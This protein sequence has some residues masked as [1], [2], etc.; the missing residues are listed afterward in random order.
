MNI[1]TKRVLPIL[2]FALLVG[3]GIFLT[4]PDALRG[5]A[6]GGC[7]VDDLTDNEVARNEARYLPMQ[8]MVVLGVGLEL[9]DEFS[10]TADA[11]LSDVDVSATECFSAE[12]T[13]QDAT[14]GSATVVFDFAGCSDRT[15]TITVH[16]EGTPPV[17]GEPPPPPP[18]SGMFA[19]GPVDLTFA[20]Y[21]AHGVML[22]GTLNVDSENGSGQIDSN[23]Q[24]DFLDYS[25]TLDADGPWTM[26][27]PETIQLDL[28]GTYASVTGLDW[29]VAIGG[30]RLSNECLGAL[31]GEMTGTHTNEIG[32]VVAVAH[33]DGTCDGCAASSVNDVEQSRI[34]FPESMIP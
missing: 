3:V 11:V 5:E 1:G 14:T 34:C 2:G 9:A 27:D 16:K 13:E 28:E 24:T 12:V 6:G 19:S 33:F 8:I 4:R 15:G 17:E 20:Q 7:A 30:L 29:Q 32:S 23:I 21:V 26:V 25:G 18:D 10:R 22:D 31:A